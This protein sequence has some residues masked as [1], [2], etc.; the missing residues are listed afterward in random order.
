MAKALFL[1][2]RPLELRGIGDIG[3]GPVSLNLLQPRR[4]PLDALVRPRQFVL[5]SRGVT[6]DLACPQSAI[7]RPDTLAL[8]SSSQTRLR[9]PR[10]RLRL[11]LNLR[12]QRR[13]RRSL[14]GKG[15]QI[16]ALPRAVPGNL[17]VQR[18]NGIILTAQCPRRLLRLI[19]KRALRLHEPAEL[20]PGKPPRKHQR[21][22]NRRRL[23]QLE[24][25]GKRHKRRHKNRTNRLALRLQPIDDHLQARLIALARPRRLIVMARLAL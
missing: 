24:I 16:E 13:T 12:R 17:I 22:R 10:L 7:D 11:R 9:R 15:L 5:R 23:H 1:P 6:V 21:R 19:P 8:G 14:L 2:L 25:L 4:C 20:P 3:G 18:R